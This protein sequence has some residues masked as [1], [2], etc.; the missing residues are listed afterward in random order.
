M[1]LSTSEKI[2]A[3]VPLF[4]HKGGEISKKQWKKVHS[5]WMGTETQINIKFGA[6]LSFILLGDERRAQKESHLTDISNV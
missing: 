3:P 5:A 1:K 6:N 4:G 2:T